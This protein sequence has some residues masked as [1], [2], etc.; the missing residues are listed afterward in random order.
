MA[1][2]ALLKPMGRRNR[3]R[4]Q[5]RLQSP[6]A[7]AAHEKAPAVLRLVRPE[8]EGI[9]GESLPG[10]CPVPAVDIVRESERSNGH[11]ETAASGDN[12][13]AATTAGAG[14]TIDRR[15][16]RRSFDAG[17]INPILNDPSVFK[18]AAAKGIERLEVTALLEDQRNILL[19][20]EGGG[21]L[22]LWHDHN[23]Y[24]VHTNFLRPSKTVGRERGP[25]VK[26]VCLAAYWWMFTHTDCMALLTK[27][28]HHNRGA[29][30]F[31]P[32]VGW[33]PEFERKAVWE[34][35][36]GEL[37]D[38]TFCAIRY[39]DWVRKTPGLI[40]VGKAFH[41]KL[42][43]E[44]IRLGAEEKPHPDEDCHDLHVGACAEMIFGGQMQKAVA[45][46]NRWA[47]FAGY[48][49]I[50]LVADPT[51]IDIGTALLKISGDDFKV[52]LVR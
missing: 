27:I 30:I 20:A 40:Q 17:E 41:D 35:V 29:L 44:F 25:Y 46:Y 16:V 47:H 33:V 7:E 34:T 2:G 22:F 48:G 52:L 32:L 51:I 26:N 24:E 49:F 39:D 9:S 6:I 4:R 8:P 28:P 45:L 36:D 13:V 3:Q 18:Y 43:Q 15:L 14:E 31:S 12:V 11:A 21:I 5:Q 23:T 19:M 50:S 1:Y 37:V 38:M 10:G 42:S